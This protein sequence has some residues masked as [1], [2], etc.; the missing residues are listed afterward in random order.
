MTN[1]KNWTTYWKNTLVDGERNEIE[2]SR[3]DNN[4]VLFLEPNEINFDVGKLDKI[5][6]EKLFAFLNKK[7]QEEDEELNITEI[8]VLISLFS[9]APSAES[10]I[11]SEENE[12]IPFWVKAILNEEGY[13]QPDEECFPYIPRAFLEPQLSEKYFYTLSDVE[14]IDKVFYDLYFDEIVWSDYWKYIQDICSKITEQNL[15][16]YRIENYLTKYGITLVVN[17]SLKGASDG[18][19]KLYD[20]IQKNKSHSKLYERMVDE[21]FPSN[22]SIRN[23]VDYEEDTKLHFGQMNFEFPLSPKIRKL[24]F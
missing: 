22:K 3:I 8:P 19:I 6:T 15:F 2:L 4:K 11:E 12:V 10:A 9:I 1:I 16:K 24:F 7:D 18:I 13:L 14:T 23:I 20:Y 5:K 17:D 21:D